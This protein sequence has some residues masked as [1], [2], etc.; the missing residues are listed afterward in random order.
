MRWLPAMAA[1]PREH[2]EIQHRLNRRAQRAISVE[3]AT[4]YHRVA[5]ELDGESR[6]D[7]AARYTF[8]PR[9]PQK[10][11]SRSGIG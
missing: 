2:N 9:A 8:R 7:V 11:E 10:G 3:V 1:T 4:A 6:D 5:G